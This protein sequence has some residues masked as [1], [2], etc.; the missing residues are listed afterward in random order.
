MQLAFDEQLK[1]I[2]SLGKKSWGQQTKSKSNGRDISQIFPPRF[3]N[4]FLI[5]MKVFTHKPQATRNCEILQLETE[6]CEL[7]TWLLK[8][9]MHI[10]ISDNCCQNF[11]HIEF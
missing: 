9:L 2:K 6:G 5:L 4:S 1:R 10:V 11:S 8:K 3:G 7:H